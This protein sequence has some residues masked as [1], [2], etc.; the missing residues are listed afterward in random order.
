MLCKASSPQRVG[1]VVRECVGPHLNVSRKGEVGVP[2]VET[3]CWELCLC[4]RVFGCGSAEEDGCCL[5]LESEHSFD[6]LV[7]CRGILD[8]APMTIG[9]ISCLHSDTI[10]NKVVLTRRRIP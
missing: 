8:V 3:R 4:A 10:W 2:P 6:G 1:V 9:V 5:G 7:A